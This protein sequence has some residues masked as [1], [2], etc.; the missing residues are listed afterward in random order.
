MIDKLGYHIESDYSDVPALQ[1]NETSQEDLKAK[2]IANYTGLYDKGIITKNKM[3]SGI[4]EEEIPTGDV[5]N[6]DE[7]KTPY[8]VKLGVGGTQSM[9]LILTDPNMSLEMKKQT[10]IIIFGLTEQEATQLTKQ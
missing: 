2:Q 4:G 8:A 1:I 5:F 9:Q 6:Y 3:L 10:L 7:N